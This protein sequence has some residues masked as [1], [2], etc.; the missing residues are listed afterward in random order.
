MLKSKIIGFIDALNAAQTEEEIWQKAKLFYQN[1]GFE[2]VSYVDLKPG[3]NVMHSNLPTWWMEHYIDEDYAA[4]DLIFD[5]CGKYSQ[6]KALGREFLD[7]FESWTP[8]QKKIIQEVGEAGATAGF[9]STVRTLGDEGVAL[10]TVTG[11][12]QKEELHR[13]WS[14]KGEVLNLAAHLAYNAMQAR[15]AFSSTPELSDVERQCVQQ[16]ASGLSPREIALRISFKPEEVN[17][18]LAMAKQKM[19]SH[20]KS[21]ELANVF[22]QHVIGY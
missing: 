1:Q 2:R 5:Y 8:V 14:E 15:I 3:R 20:S 6:P 12:M 22:A 16:F 21:A 18:H 4:H 13:I 19:A 7:I 9:S 10:W 17:Y 11:N